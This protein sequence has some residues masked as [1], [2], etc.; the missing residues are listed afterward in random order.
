MARLV[1]LTIRINAGVKAKLQG[2]AKEDYRT[3]TD[4]IETHLR[5]TARKGLLTVDAKTNIKTLLARRRERTAR[6]T[7][8]IKSELKAELQALA[9]KH[10]PTL[11]DF[12]ETEL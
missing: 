4:F 6:L 9:N 11:T 7:M 10:Y 3:L 12:I 2:L 5:Q 8:R 1:Y